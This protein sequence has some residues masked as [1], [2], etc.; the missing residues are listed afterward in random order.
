MDDVVWLVWG[1]EMYEEPWLVSIFADESEARAFADR[2][3]E[4]S[5]D[6]PKEDWLSYSVGS[7]VVIR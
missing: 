6:V 7:Q 5:E 3:N 4:G 1:H 2:C